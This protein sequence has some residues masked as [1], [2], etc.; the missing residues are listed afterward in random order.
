VS[1]LQQPHRAVEVEG[2]PLTFGVAGVWR[3]NMVIRDWQT[4]SVWQ[5]ATGEAIAGPL[6]GK[7]LHP[8]SGSLVKWGVWSTQHPDGI[9]GTEP[10][11]PAPNLLSVEGMVKLFSG[12]NKFATPGLA[13]K[14]DHRL[15]AHQMVIGVQ[16]NDEARAYPL[17]LVRELGKINDTLGGR[18]IIIIYHPTGDNVDVRMGEEP[19][20]VEH[21]WWQGWSEF[22]PQTDVFS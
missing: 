4:G 1:G 12:T 17:D 10:D 19:L 8:I 7:T 18:Q 15:P 20:R 6:K 22:H 3:R 9:L 14:D 5:H 13:A 11:P 2:Q 21:L 16:V